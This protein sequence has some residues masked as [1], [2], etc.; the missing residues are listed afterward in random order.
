MLIAGDDEAGTHTWI[1]SNYA[2]DYSRL[3][4]ARNL[5]MSVELG[6][7]TCMPTWCI[8]NCGVASRFWAVGTISK[9]S[10]VW[11]QVRGVVQV[12]DGGGGGEH[13]GAAHFAQPSMTILLLK[14]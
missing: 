14:S 10:S 3:I 5:I 8:D 13:D 11:A 1:R 2:G 9:A 6:V 12:G 7:M 4:L